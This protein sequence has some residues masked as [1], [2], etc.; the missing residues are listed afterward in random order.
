MR[1][2]LPQSSTLPALAHVTTRMETT[3]PL[4]QLFNSDISGA[5]EWSQLTKRAL[6]PDKELYKRLDTVCSQTK[7]SAGRKGAAGA[8]HSCK[9]ESI[10]HINSCIYMYT[11]TPLHFVDYRLLKPRSCNSFSTAPHSSEPPSFLQPLPVQRYRLTWQYSL[12]LP[13]VRTRRN[14]NIYEFNKQDGSCEFNDPG[15]SLELCKIHWVRYSQNCCSI[16][17]GT[18]IV[19]KQ[20]AQTT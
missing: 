5:D 4:V 2:F 10:R 13:V 17:V 1:H 16:I 14:N 20:L 6:V 7:L 18:W 11:C 9:S 3:L 15:G 12:A 8:N 19:C